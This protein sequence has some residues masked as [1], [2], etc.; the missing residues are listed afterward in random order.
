LIERCLAES[1]IPNP[2]VVI[3]LFGKGT[4]V[5]IGWN[6]TARFLTKL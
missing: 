3:D 1:E 4:F 5:D 6:V 2:L